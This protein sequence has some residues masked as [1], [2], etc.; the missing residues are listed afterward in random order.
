VCKNSSFSEDF[1]NGHIVQ[2][3]DGTY[4]LFS[5]S[6]ESFRFYAGETLE[7][8]LGHQV[9]RSYQRPDS[10]FKVLDGPDAVDLM[11]A[12]MDEYDNHYAEH[13]AKLKSHGVEF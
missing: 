10:D 8:I 3:P 9:A 12:K 6:A 13:M 1:T 11:I 2:L 7:E 4:V 5:S